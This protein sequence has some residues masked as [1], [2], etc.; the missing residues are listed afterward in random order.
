[1]LIVFATILG[2]DSIG[3]TG[4][5]ASDILRNIQNFKPEWYHVLLTVLIIFF[6]IIFIFRNTRLFYKKFTEDSEIKSNVRETRHYFL[7]LGIVLPILECFIEFFKIRAQSELAMT[8]VVS[9]LAEVVYFVSAKNKFL[10]KN[11]Q[12]IFVLFFFL[13]SG[14]YF[15]KTVFMPFEVITFAQLLIVTFFS[16][17]VFR[18]T[19]HFYLFVAFVI[20]LFTG[21]LF[22][23]IIP[24]QTN[25]VYLYSVIIIFVLNYVWRLSILNSRERLLFANNI[26]HNGSSLVIATN[27]FGEVSFVSDNIVK[28]LGYE[29]EE[30]MGLG[31]WALTQDEEF[32]N[33]DYSEIYVEDKIYIRKVK[34]RNG[35]YKYIQ[36]LDKKHND[37]LYVGIGQDV[38]EQIY[39]QE[40]YRSIIESA[41]DIIYESDSKGNF[42]FF[43]DVAKSLL[44]YETE[45]LL[46][47]H[48]TNLIRD[49]HKVRVGKFYQNLEPGKNHFEILEF[50]ILGKDK[51]EYW[52]SQ[53]VTVKR[54]ADGEITNFM[55]IVRDITESKKSELQ[56]ALVQ[57]KRNRFNALL[58][59]LTTGQSVINERLDVILNN[60]LI[61]SA[62]VL[63]IDRISLWNHFPDRIE[64][65]KV[66][67]AKT[68]EFS[69]GELLFKQEYP[70]Y[71]DA[72]TQGIT[73]IVNDISDNKYTNDFMLSPDNDL[74]SLLDVPI[75]NNGELI[76]LICFEMTDSYKIWDAE[77]I[78]FTRSIADIISISIETRRRKKAEKQLAFRSEILAAVAKITEKLLISGNIQDTLNDHFELLGEATRVDKVYFYENNIATNYLTLKNVWYNGANLNKSK[79]DD[80][81][82]FMLDEL[83]II[84]EKILANEAVN[85][86]TSEL[87]HSALKKRF[88]ERHI[89]SVLIVPIVIKKVFYGFIGF[90]NCKVERRWTEDQ[91]NILQSLV[92]NIANTIERK[93]AENAI[94]E[95][96]N[97][98]R[99]LNETIDDVFWLYD[100]IDKRILYISHSSKEV[101]GVEP[102]EFYETNNY[103]VNYI[104][105]EDKPAILDAHQK[106]ERDGFYE[107][108]Y[109][110]KTEHGVKWIYE[111][112][113]GIKNE[114]GKYAKSSG[115]CSDI[116]EKKQIETQLKQLSIVAE[117]TSNGVLIADDKGNVIWANQGYLNMME[118]S[119]NALV[120]KRPR[121]LFNPDNHE[122]SSEIDNLTGKSFTKEIEVQTFLNNRK[123]IEVNN[124]SILDA[125]GTVVQQIELV[126]DITEK[127]KNQNTLLQYSN[128]LE[129]QGTLQKKI[130]NSLTYEELAMETLGFIKNQ[131]K[132]CIRISLL[133][134]DEKNVILSGHLLENDELTLIRLI[135][136]QTSGF[137]T[138]QKG[139]IYIE[140]DLRIAG[141]KSIHD[142]EKLSKNVI[143][144]I[145]LPLLNDS[146]LIGSLNIS[147]DHV[148]DMTEN[149]IKN[150]ESFSVLI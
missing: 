127:V 30:V 55:S 124:T 61:K 93:I 143:S 11:I 50:P 63:N 56:N 29:P 78:V 5:P 69:K 81:S 102:V 14:L 123:W 31:F 89:L 83:G 107:I 19:K 103:W 144:Y 99:L 26:V 65:A 7:I 86:I 115:I 146:K 28:I 106:I 141:N 25:I 110:I 33:V 6:L 68:E 46:G 90:D 62:G 133:N 52:V 125:K 48:F 116:T 119:L 104:I 15:Y 142:Y 66:Y 132:G 57:E 71:F 38:T 72:I 137:S 21:L 54:N 12:T 135:A 118:I 67:V 47:K 27:K 18:S 1:M 109:R 85:I 122:L 121:D 17:T 39:M 96:E 114:Q 44:G 120:G 113:F 92:D 16:Y 105:D 37:D 49:D 101:L 4:T 149:Q 3:V 36:W 76:G 128:D 70:H 42:V 79:D 9:M 51:T 108:E 147:L 88:E 136:S 64:C 74:K 117:K 13:L 75:F 140:K 34:C 129:Y 111:K 60:I 148:F 23:N 22:T 139:N 130:I 95:S 87:D 112:S 8:I 94:K 126:T 138:I 80:I 100:L 35:N 97:N 45:D 145:I 59:E 24:L 43:N 131:T 2:N 32:K 73:L 91:L 84:S 53:K 77:D 150:L 10:Q 20:A 58:M 82:E 134:I 98:F 41:T 40:K